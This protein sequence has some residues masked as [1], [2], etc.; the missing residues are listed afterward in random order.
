MLPVDSTRRFSSR[1]ENYVRFRPSYPEAVIEALEREC[2]LTRDST[3][4]DIASGTGIF[5]ELLLKHGNPVFGVEPNA[6][7]RHAGE[8]FLKAYPKFTS[9]CG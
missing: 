4:A 6:E 8:E 3:V 2:G 1:V 5:T 7:M 9:V